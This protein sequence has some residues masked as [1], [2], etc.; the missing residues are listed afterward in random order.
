MQQLR[1]IAAALRIRSSGR[2]SDL[3]AE[4]ERRLR[5]NPDLQSRIDLA[6]AT[7]A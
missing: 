6:L 2:I 4:C 3:V 5:G 1:S 7:L